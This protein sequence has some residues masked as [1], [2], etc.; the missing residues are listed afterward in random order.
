[1]ARQIAPGTPSE[2]NA[3]L[4]DVKMPSF[5][6][7]DKL[8]DAQI[9]A[10]NQNFKLYAENV[11][12][13]ESAKLYEQ[14]K[15]DPIQLSNALGKLP[16]MLKGLPEELQGEMQKNLITKSISLVQKAQENQKATERKEYKANAVINADE[17]N[18][19]ISTDYFN[20]LVN[21]TSDIKKP[22]YE[23]IYVGNRIRLNEL[24]DLTDED[25]KPL[26]TDTQRNAMK[27]PK[28]SS[29]DGFKQFISRFELKQLEDWDKQYFQN[30]D[31]FKQDT[32]IDDSTYDSMETAMK[33]RIKALKDTKTREIHGQA[34]YDAANLIT[35]PIQANVE[36]AKQ[37]GVIKS[38]LIDKIV[39][40]SKKAT[41]T[42]YAYD[43][44]RKT[45]PGAFFQALNDFSDTLGNNDWSFDGR[46]K[47]IGQAADALLKLDALAKATNMSPDMVDEIKKVFYTALTNQESAQVLEPLLD[48]VVGRY[49]MPDVLV[50]DDMAEAYKGYEERKEKANMLLSAD[51]EIRNSFAY[52]QNI[53]NQNYEMNVLNAMN[54]FIVGTAIGDLSDYKQKIA[55]ADMRYKRDLV[56][57]MP[58]NQTQWNI[59]E[60]DVENGKEVVLE[61]KGKRY[62]FN[63]F[64]AQ[65]PFTI[66]Y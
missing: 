58:F 50:K 3:K 57:F 55:E 60:K 23:T 36:K 21:M 5:D 8:G 54:S 7:F 37:S 31:K 64:N 61:Y 35:E 45:S 13:T 14:F 65:K 56:A 27:M 49:T 15:N 39:K 33:N 41:E 51:K 10:A 32:L 38:G 24:A 28:Q 53:A 1:M 18:K 66:L 47:A 9:K 46:E 62:R 44:T 16:D 6:A 4:V 11:I 17:T 29:V 2:I 59:W 12:N 20:V 19:A 26:F 25:G 30:R 42:T 48:T 52:A 22:I 40:A 43:P 63:G 34:F